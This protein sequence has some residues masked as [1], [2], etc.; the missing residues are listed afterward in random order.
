MKSIPF[1]VFGESLVPHQGAAM[2]T[3]PTFFVF[4]M[5]FLLVIR[6]TSSPHLFSMI[7]FLEWTNWNK[8]L[9]GVHFGVSGQVIIK[10]SS[11]NIS[12]H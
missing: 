11:G 2:P 4:F 5:I 3:A 10:P 12:C 6:G 7:S 8:G 1:T 9:Q